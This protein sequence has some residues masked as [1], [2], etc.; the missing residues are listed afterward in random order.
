V[1]EVGAGTGALTVALAAAGADEVLAIEVDGRLLPVLA[2]A[3]ASFPAVRI[4]EADATAIDW[5]TAL[6]DGTWIACGNLPYNVGTT[7]VLDLLEATV[8]DPLVVM[9][10]REVAERLAAAPGDDGYGAVSL[11][12]AQRATARLVR[13]VPPEVFWPRPAVGSAIVRLDRRSAPLT[14]VDEEVLWRVVDVAFGQRRKTMRSAVRRL[15]LDV[16]DADALLGAA[17]VDPTSRPE[18]LDVAAFARIAELVSG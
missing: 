12:V 4:L 3:T 13:P 10:Q 8:A 1:V 2:E 16:G 7:I 14:D 15:G 17:G 5:P 9:V 18:E 6:G 11:R